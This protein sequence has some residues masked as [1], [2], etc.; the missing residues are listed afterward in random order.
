MIKAP[1]KDCVN[2][3][4]GCHATCQLYIKWKELHEW[5]VKQMRKSDA[6]IYYYLRNHSRRVYNRRRD[7]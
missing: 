7:K 2:R 3:Q 1:C 4:L 6:D 5:E